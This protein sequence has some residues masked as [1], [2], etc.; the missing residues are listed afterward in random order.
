[1]IWLMG[2]AGA[3]FES[4]A[5]HRLHLRLEDLEGGRNRSPAV[6]PQAVVGELP[7]LCRAFVVRALEEASVHTLLLHPVDRLDEVASAPC[8]ATLLPAD[9]EARKCLLVVGG[10]V[11]MAD[12]EHFGIRKNGGGAFHAAE[13]CRA[14][15]FPSVC[16]AG[17]VLL[18]V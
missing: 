5:A 17:L 4:L 1:M 3:G 7:Q 8:E 13:E 6:T 14:A 12:V 16:L 9:A 10:L 2:F 11:L 15:K 18:L